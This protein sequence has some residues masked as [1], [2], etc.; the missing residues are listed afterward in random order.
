MKGSINLNV[1]VKLT[2]GEKIEVQVS[3]NN[4]KELKKAFLHD[5]TQGKK[6][7]VGDNLIVRV[8]DISAI[9]EK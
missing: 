5:H 9:Y 6:F 2:D 8:E 3:A 4:F 1:I 7:L